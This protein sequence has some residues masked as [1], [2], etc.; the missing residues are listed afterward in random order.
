MEN[1]T[2]KAFRD[3]SVVVDDK[4]FAGC[5]FVDVILVYS[6]GV[7][8]AFVNCSFDD[9]ALQFEGT[10]ANTLRFLGGLSA[11]GFPAAVENISNTVRG[12]K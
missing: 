1:V 11:N 2:N 9:V 5:S 10:A 4:S 7:L 3:E 12:T 8:P 6:G